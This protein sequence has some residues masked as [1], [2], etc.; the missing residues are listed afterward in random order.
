MR[1]LL[2][3]LHCVDVGT[4]RMRTAA[5]RG[6]RSPPTRQAGRWLLEGGS[7]MRKSS[8]ENVGTGPSPGTG[9]ATPGNTV[10]RDSLCLPCLWPVPRRRHLGV[11]SW[12]LCRTASAILRLARSFGVR[13]SIAMTALVVLAWSK[14]FGVVQA[15]PVPVPPPYQFRVDYRYP[16]DCTPLVGLSE[17]F[18]GD[19]DAS[20]ESRQR[21]QPLATLVL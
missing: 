11:D 1:R 20:P 6:A 21:C 10:C 19:L 7:K 16:G 2:S 9:P 8:T 18:S 14:R 15:V 4:L 3:P 13:D 12:W 5:S 17:Q